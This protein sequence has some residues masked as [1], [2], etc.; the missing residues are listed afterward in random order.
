MDEYI[1]REAL[2]NRLKT[3]VKRITPIEE[4]RDMFY[5]D[6]GVNGALTA[7]M[8]EVEN[9]PAADVVPVVHGRWIEKTDL[10]DKGFYISKKIWYECSWCGMKTAWKDECFSMGVGY[11]FCPNCGA[12]MD[13]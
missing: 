11:N 5:H 1:E 9:A 12:R 8:L 7:A 3:K 2:L 6:S 10:Y 4:S 13:G